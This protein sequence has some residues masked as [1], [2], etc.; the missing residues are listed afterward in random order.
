MSFVLHAP[1]TSLVSSNKEGL[2]SIVGALFLHF[3]LATHLTQVSGYVALH[4]LGL[5]AGTVLL[6]SSPSY[7][8]RMQSELR[9]PNL[10]TYRANDHRSDSESDDDTPTRRPRGRI[11]HRRENDKTATE[12]FSY[13]VLWWVALGAVSLSGVG[14]GIS[15]RVVSDPLG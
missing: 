3:W 5:S 2:V 11:Q 12:L 8:R 13:A 14:G 7:F 15:R 4:L 1:R 9:N 6:P 10:T